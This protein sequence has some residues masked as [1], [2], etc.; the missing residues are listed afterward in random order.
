MLP[1][2]PEE[3]VRELIEKPTGGML[4]KDVVD[5]VVSLAGGHLFL[6]QY[7]MRELWKAGLEDANQD[8]LQE[9]ALDF[10]TKR[11]DFESWLTSIGDQGEHNYGF[12]A[13]QNKPLTRQE[14]GQEIWT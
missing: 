13:Q 11:R 7:L 8:L 6:V 4:P 12:L 14:I 3:G 2:C 1:A 9:I 5:G 10:T